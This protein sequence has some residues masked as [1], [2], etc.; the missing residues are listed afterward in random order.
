MAPS[1]AQSRSSRKLI[2]ASASPRRK[3]ILAAAGFDFDLAPTEV[4]ENQLRGE[5][6]AE[7][8]C[9]LAAAKAE[10]ALVAA[11]QPCWAPVLAAD[12]VVV[13]DG[14]I[15]GKPASLEEATTMLRMLSGR[16]HQVLT[17]VCLLLQT[18]NGTVRRDVRLATTTVRFATL[19]QEEIQQYVRTGEPLDKAGAY[20]VQGQASKFVERIEGCYFN[21]VG[22]P[23]A[24]VYGMLKELE[25]A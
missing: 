21:V 18:E 19:T 3:E 13:I 14:H 10:A 2:L 17:G 1:S 8:V 11:A 23:I 7:M 9:R 4:E 20:G 25:T 24:L 15:L 6:P 12:T 22:L 5:T 16:E